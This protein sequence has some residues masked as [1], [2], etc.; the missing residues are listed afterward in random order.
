MLE[1]V[2]LDVFYDEVQALRNVNLEVRKGEIVTLIGANGAGKTTTL[3][4]ISGLLNPAAGQLRFDGMLI[5]G[6]APDAIVRCGIT[7]VPE[8]RRIFPQLTVEENLKVGGNLIRDSRKIR[9]TLTQV[10]ELFPQLKERR[11]QLGQAL[12]GGE[13]QMLALGRAMMSQPRLLLLDEPSLG[14]AP[15]IVTEVARSIL[16]FRDAGITILL[17]EQNAH[18]ALTLSNRG[19]VMET[20]RIT[21]TD[22]AL[23]LRRNPD[24]LASYLGGPR[25]GRG[26]S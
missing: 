24:I 20:G 2:G 4:A 16:M 10:Y 6:L 12:S 19:Y 18:L 9:A 3:K 8:G 25:E 11:G 14:L 15:L 1:I 23:D 21:M 22:T 13:Q 5:S 7:Q 26:V 17:V